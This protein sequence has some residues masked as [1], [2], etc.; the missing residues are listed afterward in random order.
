MKGGYALSHACSPYVLSLSGVTQFNRD[1]EHKQTG[2][3][4]SQLGTPLNPTRR[5][6]IAH[7]PARRLC[8]RERINPLP[9]ARKRSLIHFNII[10]TLIT[11]SNSISIHRV[12][13]LIP[14]P[15]P[16]SI[17]PAI[18]YAF[19]QPKRVGALISPN[20]VRRP[21]GSQPPMPYPSRTQGS[22]I[23]QLSIPNPIHSCLTSP[24]IYGPAYR[25]AWSR[26]PCARG[27]SHS[28]TPW[29]PDFLPSPIPN[30]HSHRAAASPLAR[31][32]LN[33]RPLNACGATVLRRLQRKGPDSQRVPRRLEYL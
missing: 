33:A 9:T 30:S 15:S 22:T 12:P 6:Q 23:R 1:K 5:F 19:V 13:H 3:K 28:N 27:P 2:C 31:C 4:L 25:L 16:I 17:P 21:Q 11:R 14:S 26:K 7:S 24:S 8:V 29:D 32:K 10:V 20:Y 18:P